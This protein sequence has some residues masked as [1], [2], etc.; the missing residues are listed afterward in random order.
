MATRQELE[1]I[2]KATAQGRGIK[3]IERDLEALEKKGKGSAI[4]IGSLNNALGLLGLGLSTKALID[5][6]SAASEAG[7][8]QEDAINA[9]KVSATGIAD[10]NEALELGRE[11]TKG[12]AT[13]Q[14][15]AAA[16]SVLFGAG[17][18]KNAQEAADL[19]AAGTVLSN[20]F[21]SAGASQELFVRLLS[22][23]SPVLFNNFGLTAQMVKAKQ[24]EIEATTNLS[25]E[26]AKSLALKQ[27]LI[28]QSNKYKNALSE[29]SVAAATAAA[30]QGNFMAS[31]GS[32]LNSLN[33]ATGATE[34]YTA[35][36][37]KLTE[38]AK[39][40]QVVLG[41]QIPAI[42]A[43][44]SAMAA[45][46]AQT[47][48]TSQSYDELEAA[49]DAAAQDQGAFQQ[50]LLSNVD[51]HAEYQAA[52][53]KVAQSNVFLAGELDLTEQEFDNLKNTMADAVV[54]SGEWVSSLNAMSMA[55]VG[56]IQKTA[57]LAQAQADAAAAASAYAF[58]PETNRQSDAYRQMALGRTKTVE[59][60][61]Q[62]TR[63]QAKETEQEQIKAATAAGRAM[64]Q[65]FT[66]AADDIAGIIESKLQP[67]LNEV[68]SPDAAGGAQHADEWARRLATVAT[69]GFGS[70][71]LTQLQS[72]FQGQTF[73]QPIANA[74]TSGDGGQLQAAATA[75]LTQ[76]QQGLVPQLW[77][78]ELIKNQVRQQLQ[79][80]QIKEQLIQQV[81]EE[82]GAE[83]VTAAVGMVQVAAGDVGM[84]TAETET[85]VTTLAGTTET[86]GVKIKGAFDAALPSI[87]IL[88][89]RFTIMAGLIERVNQNAQNAGGSIGS[90]NPPP[91]TSVPNA[92]QRRVGGASEL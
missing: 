46:A 22:S 42:Q 86:A 79:Q 1:L 26:E 50:A 41:E 12:M 24:D 59:L 39:A 80:Q 52:I 89:Q 11:A 70:E 57:E 33:Q 63:D 10:Y 2:I 48:L 65:S 64:T 92:A 71:W 60:S 27:I 8:M 36:L 68:W 28:E 7:R 91:A 81:K 72:Q 43:H 44:E 15:L 49:T 69:G 67:S 5:F 38:G 55:S 21:A 66:K 18:A 87:D 83:G 56:A 84:A 61:E 3:D 14:S 4:S 37:N 17:L 45:S 25:S 6:S 13:D 9:L 54:T 47:I 88:N 90:M 19:A 34:I 23:G 78:V 20:V 16:Q 31:V 53:D 58:N 76:F 75:A 35:G 30:A 85:H 40:W 51:T 29:Q 32:L 74:I 73:W 77:D 82:L 62:F